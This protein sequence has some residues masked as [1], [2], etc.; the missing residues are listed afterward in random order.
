MSGRMNVV[1]ALNKDYVMYTGVMLCSLCVN[2]TEESIRVFVLHSELGEDD[3]ESI[4]NTLMGFDVEIIP[5]RIEKEQFPEQ[6][7]ADAQWSIETCYR[8]AMLDKLPEDVERLLY[9][10]VDIIVNQP[11]KELYDMDFEGNDIIAAEDSHG[12]WAP[13]NQKQKEMFLTGAGGYEYFNAGVMLM[14]MSQMR[15]KY[16]FQSYLDAMKEWN[17]EMFALDQDILN[18]VHRGCVK[19]VDWHRWDLFA[20][21]AHKNGMTYEQVRKETAIIHYVGPKPWYGAIFEGG[22]HFDIEQIWWNFAK[23]T[24]FYLEMLEVFQRQVVFDDEM[25]KYV[26]DLKTKLSETTQML[27][28]LLKIN[29]DLVGMIKKKNN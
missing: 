13:M 6:I 7:C 11:L 18:Y 1:T 2:N 8:L 15:K 29:D 26:E 28:K 3:I 20:V 12:R 25:E 21:L 17:F 19:F 16:T 10:D 9:L 22:S 4:Q 23:K 27:Q 5:L 24:P 14:N